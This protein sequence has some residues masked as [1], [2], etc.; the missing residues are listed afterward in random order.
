MPAKSS[1]PTLPLPRSW[2]SRVKS[3]I[4]QVI[5]LAQFTMAHTRGWAANSPNSRIRLKADLDRA[6]QEIAL[7]CEELRIHQ[8]RM[9]QLPPHRRPYYPP[10]QRM[11]ILQLRAARNWS[12]EQTAKAFLVTAETIASWLKRIDEQ[13]PDALVQLFEPVNKYPDFVRYLV[14]QLKSLCPML[15]KMKISQILARAGLH[16]G[17]ATVGR[18]LKEEPQLAPPANAGDTASKHRIVTAKYP[19]H[20]WHTD[21][22]VVPT[23]RGFWTAWLPFT[24]PQCW[25][26]AWW[27]ALAEDHFSRRVMGYAVF[28]KEPSSTEVC[29]MLGQAVATAGKAPRHIVCDQGPQ[30]YC[31]AFKRWCKRSGIKPPRYGAIG[32]QGSLAVI[33]RLILTLKTLLHCLPLVPLRKSD[34]R[35]EVGLAIDW[36]NEQR[37][38]MTL[39]GRTPNEVYAGCLS[40]QPQASLRTA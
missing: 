30:F 5:S 16:L 32:K 14:Q 25:P 9:A 19:G 23:A 7:L 12:L 39:G 31:D 33:E 26:F 13:G 22:T 4:L 34:F 17:V 18:M 36:Y 35:H 2:T 20:L 37:P 10:V 11:A 3:A 29:R 24:L 27:L 28:L 40:G 21:L 15:G 8:A 6:H 1:S 38:H